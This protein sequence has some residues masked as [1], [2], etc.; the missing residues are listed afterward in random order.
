[1]HVQQCET[2]QHQIMRREYLIDAKP[3]QDPSVFLIVGL[4]RKKMT[5][6]CVVLPLQKPGYVTV[7]ILQNLQLL[8]CSKIR[9]RRNYME[10]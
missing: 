5:I 9:I 8:F 2:V 1:M 10:M 4:I 7:L 3:S 6:F